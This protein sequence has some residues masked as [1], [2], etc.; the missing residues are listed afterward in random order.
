MAAEEKGV[1]G[2]VEE[3]MEEVHSLLGKDAAMPKEVFDLYEQSEFSDS[4]T[5]KTPEHPTTSSLPVESVSSK[6]AGDFVRAKDALCN[7]YACVKCNE[8]LVAETLSAHRC[9]DAPHGAL[10]EKRGGGES[11]KGL[12]KTEAK[13]PDEAEEQAAA[14]EKDFAPRYLDIESHCGVVDHQL[15]TVCTRS[16]NCKTHS[17]F[18]KRAVVGRS[19]TFD[20]L[21]KR[22]SEMK[23][24]RK[25][26]KLKDNPNVAVRKRRKKNDVVAK[27][28]AEDT[29]TE[30]DK[31]KRAE[32]EI[33]KAI[34]HHP[35]VIDKTFYLPGVKFDTLAIRSIFFQPL[36]VQR[37]QNIEKKTRGPGTKKGASAS[38]NADPAPVLKE[39]AA[40][41]LQT[42]PS[43]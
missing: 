29:V 24:K 30:K 27:S 13:L 39:E 7:V 32:E 8:I 20:I 19:T 14:A 5:L 33:M 28:K 2:F 42:T 38:G 3:K 22:D 34:M 18:L 21:L 43:S 11:T 4:V 23:K 10:K 6:E 40:A 36:K 35:P 1:D 26:Q 16:L 9:Q 12:E 25:L 17:V 31:L 37:T 41:H 15:K